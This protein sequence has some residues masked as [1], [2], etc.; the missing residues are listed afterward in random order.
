MS[1]AADKQKLVPGRRV[2]LFDLNLE[3]FEPGLVYYFCS[4]ATNGTTSPRQ[5]LVQT[6]TE[7]GTGVNEKQLLTLSPETTAGTFTLTFDAVESADLPFSATSADIQ[8]ALDTIIGSGTTLCTGVS[9]RSGGVTVEFIGT[10]AETDVEAI[11]A[12]SSMTSPDATPLQWKG[13]SYAPMPITAE[14]F[15]ISGRGALPT[16]TIKI[17]NIGL[18]PSSI[19][20]QFGDPVGAKLTRWVTYS[21]Y[22]DDGPLADPNEHYLPEI[23]VVERKKVQNRLFVEFELSA[24]MDQQGRKLPGRQVIRDACVLRY[25]TH[26]PGVTPPTFT[27]NETDMACPW[28]GDGTDPNNP[29]GP[30][31]TRTGATTANAAEDLCGKKLKDCKLRFGASAVLPFGGFPGVSRIKVE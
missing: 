22:L 12:T 6:T 2:E 20:K 8:T 11:V 23:W 29:E 5:V 19:I 9:L 3:R 28:A 4:A 17:A 16:P 30:Y 1:I 25:R 26:V 21:H 15:E 31:Y 10:L 7:G 27:Y 14:G 24:A 18:L 13:K